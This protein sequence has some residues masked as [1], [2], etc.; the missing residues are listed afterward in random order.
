MAKPVSDD[1][2][3]LRKRARR[4][5]V[6]AVILVLLMVVFLP[7]VLDEERKPLPGTVVIQIPPTLPADKAFPP[8]PEASSPPP[9]T[10]A[11]SVP[12]TP[13]TTPDQSA[14]KPASFPSRG[15]VV[16]SQPTEKAPVPAPPTEAP[17]GANPEPLTQQASGTKQTPAP[18][19]S[20]PPRTEAKAD[21]AADVLV[22]RNA[23]NGGDGFVVQL[24]A[25][26]NPDNARAL[27]G[28]LKQVR[29]PGYV[30]TLRTPGGT[31]TR[32][33][34][35]PYASEAAALKDRDRILDLKLAS[36]DLRVGRKGD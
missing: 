35:G 9:G 11:E 31:K 18:E 6:G 15:A 12:A 13:V 5:L 33:R 20:P 14:S 24:G 34:A 10:P 30:E 32:V 8:P 36:G 25:F 23:P 29:I 26:S 16:A 17:V 3:Q 22:H 27:L 28:R 19:P 7:M 21:V 1:E 4:R 2:L